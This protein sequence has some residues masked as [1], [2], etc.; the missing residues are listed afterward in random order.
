MDT[1]ADGTGILEQYIRYTT[2][3]TTVIYLAL[4]A[5]RDRIIQ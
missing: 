4:L 3:R 2:T 1:E 5:L